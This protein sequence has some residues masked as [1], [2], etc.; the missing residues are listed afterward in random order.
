MSVVPLPIPP[1][2]AST[3]S[4]APPPALSLDARVLDR[5]IDAPSFGSADPPPV[6][7]QQARAD[8]AALKPTLVPTDGRTVAKALDRIVAVL[9]TPKNADLDAWVEACIDAFTDAGVPA[10]LVE[11]ARRRA[12]TTLRFPPRPVELVDLIRED[13]AR[14]KL[15]ASRIKAVLMFAR[16]RGE[17]T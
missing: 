12:V 2:S 6:P 1:H 17:S 8:L 5:W 4:G 14:R 16:W 10:D 3:S 9:G 15:A 11:V 13:L 7:I